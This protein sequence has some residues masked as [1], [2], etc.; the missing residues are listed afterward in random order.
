MESHS[1]CAH[2]PGLAASDT[3]S[4]IT[5]LRQ[6]LAKR[7]SHTDPARRLQIQE[8]RDG[9]RPTAVEGHEPPLPKERRRA[10][11]PCL[12]VDAKRSRHAPAPTTT[13]SRAGS[14]RA[15]R[16][17]DARRRRSLSEFGLKYDDIRIESDA[18][19]AKALDRLQQRV[20]IKFHAPSAPLV[21][22]I[23]TSHNR[24]R[25]RREYIPHSSVYT[26][27]CRTRSS[28]YARGA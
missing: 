12:P 14:S 11:I 17:L 7:S 20:Q 13:R 23:S 26:Q 1:N 3:S 8:S 25:H 22:S 19:Y 21:E 16:R 5:V 24:P 6:P 10:S 28:S 15:P 18:D 9:A 27:A 2:V 4:V